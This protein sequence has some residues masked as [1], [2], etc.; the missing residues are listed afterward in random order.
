MGDK[1][2]LAWAADN[3]PLLCRIQAAV[4]PA[5]AK[6]DGVPLMWSTD[7]RGKVSHLK[8]QG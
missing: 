1:V 4:P 6:Y 5:Q 3:R 8:L 7:G 2:L